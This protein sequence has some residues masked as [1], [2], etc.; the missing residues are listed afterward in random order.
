[1]DVVEGISVWIFLCQAKSMY[2]NERTDS[3][4]TREIT[5]GITTGLCL[6]F[7]NWEEHGGKCRV[8]IPPQSLPLCWIE[9]AVEFL[10]IPVVDWHFSSEHIE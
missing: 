9:I 3:V 1:M 8:V 10:N 2:S 4:A 6:F 5:I 7:G